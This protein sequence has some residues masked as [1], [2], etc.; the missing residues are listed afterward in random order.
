MQGSAGFYH[1]CDEISVEKDKAEKL[2]NEV[3]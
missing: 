2:F 3:V 1:F